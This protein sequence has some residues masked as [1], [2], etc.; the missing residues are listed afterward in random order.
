LDSLAVLLCAVA[1]CFC[2]ACVGPA[3]HSTPA[4][5][6]ATDL[7]PDE[8]AILPKVNPNPALP[9]IPDRTFDFKILGGIGDGQTLNTK[10]FKNAIATIAK[11]GGGHLVIPTGVYKT[12]PFS[13]CSNLDLHLEQGAVIQAPQTFAE[14]GL[15]DPQTL[16]N[17]DEVKKRVIRPSALINGL[18]LHDIAITGTGAIDGSGAIWWAWSE[19]AGRQL[20]DPHRIFYPRPLL[21]SIDGC[22]RLHIDGVTFQNSPNCHVMLHRINDLLVEHM[23]VRA[24]MMS[25][26]TDGIDPWQSNNVIIRDCD[27][28]TG[29]DNICVKRSIVNCL[30]ENCR[31]GHGHGISIGSQTYDG[32]HD[33]LVRHCTFDGTDNGIRIKS[34]IGRG[35]LTSHIRFTDLQMNDVENVIDFDSHYVDN[36]HPDFSG[37]AKLVPKVD[38]IL[39]DHLTADNCLR[40]GRMTGLPDAPM[41]NIFLRDVKIDADADLVL[42]DVRNIHFYNVS[43]T[44]KEGLKPPRFRIE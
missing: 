20:H 40:F 19:R 16:K 29:D 7:S 3:D 1:L 24:P 4:P 8:M 14:Y 17:N 22:Q 6:K 38:G 43:V 27:I 9:N 37:D 44:L 30:I 2:A 42:K 39:I 5:S 18:N 10:A 12:T 23:K 28:D 11:Q 41:S 34:M 31:I 21:F 25:P 35:G 32:V 13:L 15:P 26:N 36:N 33:M